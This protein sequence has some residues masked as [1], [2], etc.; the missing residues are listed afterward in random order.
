M[1]W[2]LEAPEVALQDFDHQVADLL[3]KLTPDLLAWHSLR[4][5][6]DLDFYCG[7]FMGKTNEGVTVSP[8][9]LRALS[10]RGIELGL[11]LYAPS[12]GA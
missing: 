8:E 4:E 6:F 10:E 7:W 9:T 5:R 2:V 12:N 11:E 3:R 1:V